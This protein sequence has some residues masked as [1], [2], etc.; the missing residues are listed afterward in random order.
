MTDQELINL[1]VAARDLMEWVEVGSRVRV[2]L[3]A[4]VTNY[5][6]VLPLGLHW[7]SRRPFCRALWGSF[8]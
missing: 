5:R 2:R 4:R 3:H 6:L 1:A 8:Y 7:H